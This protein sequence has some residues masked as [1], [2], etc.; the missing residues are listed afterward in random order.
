MIRS[1]VYDD[2][3]PVV[4][5]ILEAQLGGDAR[6]RVVKQL[7]AQQVDWASTLSFT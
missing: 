7:S 2:E 4:M 5:K 6:W 1:R 3:M